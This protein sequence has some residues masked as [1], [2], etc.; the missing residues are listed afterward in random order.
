M[1]RNVIVMLGVHP[2]SKERGGIASV[3]DV[4]RGSGLFSRWPIAY[5]GTF[6]SGSALTKIAVAGV[7]LWRYLRLLFAGRVMLVHAQTASRASF[8]RKSIFILF[9]LAARK[10]VI[11]HLHGGQFAQFYEREC[12]VLRRW[13]VRRLL[14]RV[15]R[16]VVLSS[17]WQKLIE[18]IAPAVKA[19]TI[20]NPVTVPAEV[21][22]VDEREQGALLFLGR[23]G[24]RK[25]IFDLLAALAIVK[26]RFPEARLRCA[27]EGDVAGV[28]ARARELGVEENVDLLG[29]I[30]GP[31]KD[32]ELSRAALYVLPSYAEGLPMGVL[33]AMAAGIPTVASGVG[34]IPDAIEDGVEGF[35][36]NPGDIDALANRLARLLESAELRRQFA[37]AARCK[38]RKLFSTEIVLSQVEDLY[39]NLG[40]LPRT[41]RNRDEVRTGIVRTQE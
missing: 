20:A 24:Q 29:W 18:G 39:R 36:V 31:D 23:L 25:G 33:E 12:G 11:L 27:G 2:A 16:V 14:S 30:S 32:W 10:P 26:Q 8:W 19:V 4:Y 40:A 35:L 38:V 41:E 21:R 13:F 17:Q 5:I 34:G 1:D 6:S 15:D 28:R 7:A 9:A 3:V 22:G 37:S